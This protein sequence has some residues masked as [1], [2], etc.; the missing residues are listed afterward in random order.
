MA[1]KIRF[2]LVSP[3]KLLYGGEV[4]MVVLPAADGDMGV[5]P[6]HAPVI[7]AIRP[8]TICIFDGEAVAERLFISGGFVE[9]TPERCTV[10]GE[11]V[12]AVDGIDTAPLPQRIADLGEDVA[13]AE[14]ADSAQHSRAALAVAEAR[15]HAAEN[16]AYR[17]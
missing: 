2:E 3:E 1:D 13:Q 5:L 14:D 6:G 12:E 10:L 16:P 11:E 8:G 17:R 4:D 7:A 15:L 9:V